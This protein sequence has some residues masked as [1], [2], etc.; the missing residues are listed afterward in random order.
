MK[1]L[2]NYM[3]EFKEKLNITSDYKLAQELNVKRQQ[4]SRI[5]SG[6]VC[7]GREKC[8]RMAKALKIDPWEIIAAME[9]QKEKKSEMH[10]LWIKLA[11]EKESERKQQKKS[12][13]ELDHKQLLK[14]S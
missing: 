5:R 9:A 10:A 7:I 3:D 11:K 4:I 13:S 6:I 2:E 1:T 12:R 8:I 14:A